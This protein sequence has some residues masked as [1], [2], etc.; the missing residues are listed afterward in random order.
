MGLLTDERRQRRI[1]G[2]VL[3]YENVVIVVL[4]A[5]SIMSLP[6]LCLNEINQSVALQENALLPGMAS[7]SMFQ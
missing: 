5:V 6:L 4:V 1:I 3:E 7:S 2:K